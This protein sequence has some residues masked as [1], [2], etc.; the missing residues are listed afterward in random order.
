MYFLLH[1]LSNTNY[2]IFI[3]QLQTVDMVHGEVD[4]GFVLIR[5]YLGCSGH[6]LLMSW[7]NW[8]IL[9]TKYFL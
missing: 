1:L 3:L 8:V 6:G 9:L 7:Q 5:F 4:D 2:F